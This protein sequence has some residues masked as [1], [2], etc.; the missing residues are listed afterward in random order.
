MSVDSAPRPVVTDPGP[1][2]SVGL[3]AEHLEALA[4]AAGRASTYAATV[5]AWGSELA[6]RYDGGAHLIACGNGGS[7]AEAQHLTAEQVKHLRGGARV[8]DLHIVLGA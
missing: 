3:V 7:A 6:R 1:A 4:E 5:S 8:D 2:G